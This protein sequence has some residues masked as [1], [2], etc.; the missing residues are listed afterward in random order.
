V[1]YYGYYVPYD[2]SL[3][4]DQS[5]QQA[6][7]EQS[8]PSPNADANDDQDESDRPSDTSRYGEH[9]F[10]GSQSKRA[11]DEDRV[12]TQSKP[13]PAAATAD[14]SPM[15]TLVYRDGHKS[16]VRNYAIVGDNL[17]DLTKSPVLKKIPLDSLDLVAT[18]KQNE[19][20]GVEF[21]TP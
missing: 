14:D 20:N 9:Y 2:S 4:Y 8:P 5:Q 11:L 12:V 18:R 17:I 16:E 1:P 19:D 15:T 10:D 21:H 7:Q 3:D 13:A 6:Q